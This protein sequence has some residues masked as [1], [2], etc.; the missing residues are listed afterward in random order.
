MLR[1]KNNIKFKKTI[2]VCLKLV[3]IAL[4]Q[5]YSCIKNLSFFFLNSMEG[6]MKGILY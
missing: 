1:F 2:Q 6:P 5:T 4:Q 3:V